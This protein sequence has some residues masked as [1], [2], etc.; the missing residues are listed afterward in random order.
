MPS[1]RYLLKTTICPEF[2][3]RVGDRHGPLWYNARNGEI[4]SLHGEPQS[5]GLP[6]EA[7]HIHIKYDDL[8]PK[9]EMR[10]SFE[11][12]TREQEFTGFKFVMAEIKNYRV[13]PKSYKS[14]TNFARSS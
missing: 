9:A 3:A 6:G 10:G 14:A 12:I 11:A 13:N 8:G 5:T 1:L 7:R 4:L 2:T